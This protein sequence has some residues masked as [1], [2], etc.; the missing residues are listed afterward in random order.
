MQP[1]STNEESGIM[2]GR[3]SPAPISNYHKGSKLG[4]NM[5]S[6]LGLNTQNRP[7][8]CHSPKY[9]ESIIKFSIT[10]AAGRVGWS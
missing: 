8:K 5:Q 6:K 10:A 2:S 7:Q 4:P 1:V 3:L 9:M